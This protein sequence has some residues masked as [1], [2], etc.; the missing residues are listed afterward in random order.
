MVRC[1]RRAHATTHP[2]LTVLLFLRTASGGKLQ[3]ERLETSSSMA[4]AKGATM[5]FVTHFEVGSR[6]LES[7][8]PTRKGRVKV[9]QFLREGSKVLWAGREGQGGLVG[10]LLR[11]QNTK[12]S[13]KVGLC[14]QIWPAANSC[15]RLAAQPRDQASQFTF[16]FTERKPPSLQNAELS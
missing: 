13:T 1:P 5:G 4:T 9:G 15:P 12:T 11:A 6:L 14:P 8:M 7:G 10:S 16:A 2:I 3:E